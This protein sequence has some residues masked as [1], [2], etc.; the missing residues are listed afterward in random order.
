[1]S[2]FMFRFTTYFDNFEISVSILNLGWPLN[3]CFRF[4]ILLETALLSICLGPHYLYQDSYWFQYSWTKDYV[5]VEWEQICSQKFNVMYT[6]NMEK[7]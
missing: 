2:Y 5:L 7:Y 4:C 6:E 1:M 3:L